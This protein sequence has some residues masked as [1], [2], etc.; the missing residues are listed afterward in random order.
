MTKYY[1]SHFDEG[2]IHLF[3]ITDENILHVNLL[4]H[5]INRLYALPDDPVFVIITEEE[6]TKGLI[7]VIIALDLT[8]YFN[9]NVR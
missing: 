5:H 3:K 6:F 9:Y 7:A 1:K 4:S 2:S 8:D